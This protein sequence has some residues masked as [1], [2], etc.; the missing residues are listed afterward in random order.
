MRVKV[1]VLLALASIVLLGSASVALAADT[2]PGLSGLPMN[3]SIDELKQ[4]TNSYGYPVL[5]S[6]QTTTAAPNL[7]SWLNSGDG[8]TSLPDMSGSVPGALLTGAPIRDGMTMSTPGST[9]LTLPDMSAQSRNVD[10]N[11]NSILGMF[12]FY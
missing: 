8:S 4:A 5:D 6:G 9:G 3:T 1:L 2:I 7:M 11:I 10:A 12:G